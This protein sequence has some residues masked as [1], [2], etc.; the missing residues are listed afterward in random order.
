MGGYEIKFKLQTFSGVE[1][2]AIN[3]LPK[4]TT[5]PNGFSLLQEILI[6]VRYIRFKW[7]LDFR[8]ILFMILEIS[9]Q[10]QQAVI[11]LKLQIEYSGKY[12]AVW[13]KN[14]F[15]KGKSFGSCLSVRTVVVSRL[16]VGNIFGSTCLNFKI[17]GSRWQY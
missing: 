2:E 1:A 11:I 6:K 3:Q 12:I 8:L 13:F 4:K 5:A 7:R 10:I 15:Y 16:G 17:N 14:C 9:N